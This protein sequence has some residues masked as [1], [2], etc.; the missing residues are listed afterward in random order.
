MSSV[1]FSAALSN[2]ATLEA[3]RLAAIK[4]AS[5]AVAAL[6]EASMEQLAAIVP[7]TD[8]TVSMGK[9]P[10]GSRPNS[11]AGTTDFILLQLVGYKVS[12]NVLSKGI[13]GLTYTTSRSPSEKGLYNV[14]HTRERVNGQTQNG[15]N[16][17]QFG[18]TVFGRSGG[19]LAINPLWA[20]AAGISPAPAKAKAKSEPADKSRPGRGLG[21]A[22][23]KAAALLQEAKTKAKSDKAR[24]G[25]KKATPTTDAGEAPATE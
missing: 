14:G 11:K 3:E 21:K 4:A 2:A 10:T 5:D 7:P 25:G 19:F 12:E 8:C 20:T 9:L 22:T 6:P 23:R 17:M 16:A 18:C 24:K 13:E 1:S 15:A